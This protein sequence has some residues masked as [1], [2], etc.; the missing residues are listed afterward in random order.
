MVRLRDW[1]VSVSSWNAKHK[2]ER[3]LSTPT[4]V[5][6]SCT[7]CV[8][9]FQ[10]QMTLKYPTCTDYKWLESQPVI[11]LRLKW[12][13]YLCKK[14]NEQE[15]PSISFPFAETGVIVHAGFDPQLPL[16]LS[17]PSRSSSLFFSIII[18]TYSLELLSEICKW[19]NWDKRAEIQ[20]D[21]TG[22][23][24][25]PCFHVTPAFCSC[26]LGDFQEWRAHSIAHLKCETQHF[27]L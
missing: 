4:A 13:S 7:H 3:V 21:S 5:C 25:C 22:L 12:Q 24:P 20:E 2:Q 9:M 14:M 23:F 1:S 8:W 15:P 18:T 26:V 27:S 16:P 17:L 6:C 19:R 10:V 11:W